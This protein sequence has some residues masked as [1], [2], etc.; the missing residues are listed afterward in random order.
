MSAVLGRAVEV[1]SIHHYGLGDRP[2]LKVCAMI[3]P[4]RELIGAT[5]ADREVMLDTV[6]EHLSAYRS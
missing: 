6:Y 4:R 3:Y 2:S 5:D 1:A